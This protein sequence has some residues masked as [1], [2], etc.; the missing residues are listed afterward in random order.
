VSLRAL[1]WARACL[2][3]DPTLSG[4]ARTILLLLAESCNHTTG[5]AFTGVWLADESGVSMRHVREHLHRL[6]DLGYIRV[7]QQV[8]ASGVP[9]RASIVTFP[10]APYL[11]TAP[12]AGDRGE[13]PRAPDAS[14]IGPLTPA[15]PIPGSIPTSDFNSVNNLEVVA[16]EALCCDG[17][18]W[19][20]NADSHDVSPCPL[21]HP[22]GKAA[23]S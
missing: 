13:R 14:V 1:T 15:S 21:H 3:A 20:Y 11:S 9:C 2:K 4:N 16:R 18:G 6:R 17:T 12:D 10:T 19:V 22:R 23:G 7:E 8:N 5:L